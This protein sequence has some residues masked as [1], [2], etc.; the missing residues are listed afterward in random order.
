MADERPYADEIRIPI[1]I[2]LPW[3]GKLTREGK[4]WP[5]DK[6]GRDWP[7]HRGRPVFPID[8]LPHGFAPGTNDIYRL[9][10]QGK[11]RSVT[12]Q[13]A[14]MDDAMRAELD[15]VR[16]A[17]AGAPVRRVVDAAPPSATT[18]NGLEVSPAVQDEASQPRRDASAPS[19]APEPAAQP[20][21]ETQPPAEPPKPPA[22]AA[23]PEHGQF[24]WWLHR[25]GLAETRHEQ[26]TELRRAMGAD[27]GVVYTRDGVPLDVDS[28]S[29]DEVLALDK[30]TR[31]QRTTPWPLGV[32]PP[33]KTPW[34]WT[35]QEP[36]ETALK[37]LKHPGTHETVNGHVPTLQEAKRM[38]SEIGAKIEREEEGHGPNSVSSHHEPH[39]NYVTPEDAVNE[40]LSKKK[41]TVI[42]QPWK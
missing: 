2:T 27:G 15:R 16:K 22:A 24:W 30:E 37:Q 20:L 9:A 12:E 1:S 23:E 39:I 10:E 40:N 28:M 38:L 3:S 13:F 8:Q 32:A 25:H 36:Y 42:V 31:E 14:A 5:V 21:A 34:G 26:A 11:A 17:V 4:P 18:L 19:V 35:G 41:A 6:K 29:D 33:R 7:S